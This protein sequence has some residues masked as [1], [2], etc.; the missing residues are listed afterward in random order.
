M[1]MVDSDAPHQQPTFESLRDLSDLITSR[2]WKLFW[3]EV[4]REMNQDVR[5]LVRASGDD[6][7]RLQQA[8]LAVDHLSQQAER[9]LVEWKKELGVQ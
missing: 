3:R 9:W 7:I 5:R 4:E 2:G 8:I 1:D 6:V